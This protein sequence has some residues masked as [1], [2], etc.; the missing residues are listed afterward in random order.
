V[1][2]STAV[3]IAAPVE[4]RSA[5]GLLEPGVVGLLRPILLLPEGIT[6]RLTPPQLEAVLAHELCHVRRRDNLFA[7]IHMLVEATFW[8]HPLV[9]WIGARLIEERERAC[10]EEVLSLGNQPHVYAEGI[11]NVCKLYVESPLVCVSGVSGSDVKKRIEAI[12]L[13]RLA[14]KLTFVKKA[15]LAALGVVA[16]VAPL[17]VG[18][19][20]APA[21]LAQSSPPGNQQPP[22]QQRAIPEPLGGAGAVT[23]SPVAA[24]ASIHSTAAPDPANPAEP[25]PPPDARVPG[26]VPVDVSTYVIGPED[27]L[28]VRVWE[29]PELGCTCVVRSDGMITVPLIGEIK[30][31]G[32]TPLELKQEITDE[33]SAKALNDPQ[34]SVSLVGAHSKKYYLYGQVKSGG[35]KELIMPT[36][37]LEA[38]VAAGGFMDFANKRDIVIARGDKRFKFNFDEVMKG[39]NLDQNIPS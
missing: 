33:L 29:Q 16:L 8:F 17:V 7:S 1:R 9:W 27:D 25:T 26:A 11:L 5:P 28:L 4:I 30:A 39:E 31:A 34:V 12:L 2:S 22:A 35:M 18:T 3:D 19:M 21:M 37:V 10:D 15:A 38:I 13:N 20:H 32:L 14:L 36:T 6:E 23:T 24:P